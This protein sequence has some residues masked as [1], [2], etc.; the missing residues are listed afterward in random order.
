MRWNGNKTW[1]L[2][3]VGL[4]EGPQ[5]RVTQWLSHAKK[6]GGDPMDGNFHTESTMVLWRL[7]NSFQSS[8][9][10]SHE[11]PHLVRTEDKARLILS[12]NG[13]CTLD[14]CLNRWVAS[15][16]RVSESKLVCCSST[17]LK[18]D[19]RLLAEVTGCGRWSCLRFSINTRFEAHDQLFC[20]SNVISM[21]DRIGLIFVGHQLTQS[22]RY[23]G[24]P[25]YQQMLWELG[26]KGVQKSLF[27]SPHMQEPYQAH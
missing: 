12:L 9:W 15:W 17:Y 3:T 14:N 22:H 4:A 6:T 23:V 24:S 2:S 5:Y 19:P 26:T 10:V 7:C 8:I 25:N 1:F 13:R 11:Y 18:K 20:I 21:F 27:S 16:Y